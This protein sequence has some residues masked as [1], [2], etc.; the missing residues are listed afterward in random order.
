MT[1]DII[2]SRFHLFCEFILNKS[3]KNNTENNRLKSQHQELI[4]ILFVVCI[5]LKNALKKVIKYEFF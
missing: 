2:R 1:Y 4:K 3:D 5:F